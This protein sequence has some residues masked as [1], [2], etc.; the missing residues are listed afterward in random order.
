VQR[1]VTSKTTRVRIHVRH[2]CLRCRSRVFPWDK[3][4][5]DVLDPKNTEVLLRS[6]NN[7][8]KVLRTAWC[9]SCNE[10]HTCVRE[11]EKTFLRRYLN[12]K[13]VVVREKPKAKRR[14]AG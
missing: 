6:A 5:A 10:W 1:K 2:Y 11:D 14:K 9:W 7:A 4:D 12:R 13:G 3:Y 8:R